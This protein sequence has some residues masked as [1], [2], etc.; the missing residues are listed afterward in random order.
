MVENYVTLIVETFQFYP[1][2]SS[3]VC[4][5]VNLEN[6]SCKRNLWFSAISRFIQFYFT[7]LFFSNVNRVFPLEPHSVRSANFGLNV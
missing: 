3:L 4:A 7:G 5:T 6:H 2:V 1:Y